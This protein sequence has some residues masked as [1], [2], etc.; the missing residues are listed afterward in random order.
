MARFLR[1]AI[2]VVAC[3]VGLW[4]W[5][6]FRIFWAF[7]TI[8]HRARKR[9]TA[10][11]LQT[12]ATNLLALYPTNAIPRVSE[13]GTNFPQQLLTIWRSPPYI[14]IYEAAE[15]NFRLIGRSPSGTHIY[16]TDTNSPAW[17][18]LVW[19][20]G[21][22]GHCGFEIG[23]TNFV[24]YQTHARAWQPGVYFWSDKPLKSVQ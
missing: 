16:D 20:G 21:V 19:G 9:I 12:W 14:H 10:A 2:A 8:E 23:P 15:G 3:L 13:L 6:P 24:S 17:V 1:Y 4:Y 7:D 18:R 11:E 5:L 22:I